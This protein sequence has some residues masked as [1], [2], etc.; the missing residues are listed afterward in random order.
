MDEQSLVS[1]PRT[2]RTSVF[3]IGAKDVGLS[4]SKM[5]CIRSGIRGFLLYAFLAWLFFAFLIRVYGVMHFGLCYQ[6]LKYTIQYL[7]I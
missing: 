3:T 1:I 5:G 6:H 2:Q 7:H 4:I